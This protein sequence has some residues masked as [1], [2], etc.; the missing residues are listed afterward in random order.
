MRTSRCCSSAPT[1]S[2]RRSSS[3]RSRRRSSRGRCHWPARCCAS[4]ATRR[5]TSLS[6]CS[7]RTTPSATAR[8]PWPATSTARRVV[9]ADGGVDVEAVDRGGREARSIGERGARHG[10]IPRAGRDPQVAVRGARRR[11][12]TRGRKRVADDDLALAYRRPG[13][14]PTRSRSSNRCSPTP[15]GS[16]APSTPP[17]STPSTTSPPPTTQQGARRTLDGCAERTESSLHESAHARPASAR[18]NAWGWRR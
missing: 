10:R 17:R 18:C 5:W 6:A 7:G 9:R 12:G 15:S 14:S 1:S 2:L 13:A 3:S 11:R 4:A 8:S 16:S